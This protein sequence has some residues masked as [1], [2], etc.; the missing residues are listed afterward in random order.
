[1]NVEQMKEAIRICRKAH[2][3]TMVWGPGG[4]GK[5]EGIEQ[6][7]KEDNLQYI[8]FEAPVREPVDICGYPAEEGKYMVWKRPSIL[9][10]DGEGIFHIDEL[11]DCANMLMKAL[12]HLILKNEVAGHKVPD[13]WYIVGS[14]NRPEDNGM[15]NPLP[16]PLITRMVHLG[17]YCTAPD[18]TSETPESA[19]VDYDAFTKW[20]FQNLHELVIAFLKFKSNFVYHHQATPRTWEY[21]SKLLNVAGDLY[22]SFVF[23]QIIAGTIGAGV[24]TEFNTFSEMAK[25]VP[26]IDNLIKNPMKASV[27]AEN[28]KGILYAIVTSLIY[29]LNDKTETNIIKYVKRLPNEFQFYFFKSAIA[30][31]Q[32]LVSNQ[33]YIDWVNNHK[34]FFLN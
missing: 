28:K 31:K 26:N 25:K 33:L 20:G 17:V 15:G 22:E 4:V 8:C 24:A 1:M 30:V 12:Y 13:T 7:A 9:P 32:T 27:P 16:A 21:V 5:T 6:V 2:L 11:P 14:G 29:R 34:D 18:F 3:P 19:D 23:K 10:E